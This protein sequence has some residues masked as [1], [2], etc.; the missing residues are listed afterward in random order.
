MSGLFTFVVAV[1]SLLLSVQTTSGERE[2][3]LVNYPLLQDSEDIAVRSAAPALDF[4]QST[5]N[6]LSGQFSTEGAFHLQISLDRSLA[7]QVQ[8]S[9]NLVSWLSLG[10]PVISVN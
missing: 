10:S 4:N 1:A 7:Y 2:L 6:I 9:S 5:L 3:A 8:A